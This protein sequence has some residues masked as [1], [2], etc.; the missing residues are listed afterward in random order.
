MEGIEDWSGSVVISS[1]YYSPK[2]INISEQFGTFFE[3]LGARIIAIGDNNAKRQ[4]RI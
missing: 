4:L 3:T 1:V 2:H